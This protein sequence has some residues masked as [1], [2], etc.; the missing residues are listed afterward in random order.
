VNLRRHVL[1]L[2]LSGAIAHASA[3]QPPQPRAAAQS[4]QAAAPI[5]LTGYWVSVITED[6]RFRMVTP[7]KGDF[8]GV[9][10]NAT[11]QKAALS[12]DPAR[13]VASGEQCR[14]YGAGGVMRLPTRLRVSWENDTTLKVETDA[15]QQTR[16]FRFG[17][18]RQEHERTSAN[19]S[20]SSHDWQGYS[21][22]EWETM[23]QGQGQAPPGGGG[24][25]GGQG[26]PALSGALK[27]VTSRMRP[28]YMRR[29]GLPYSDQAILTEYY[30]R[31]NEPSGDSWLILT[32]SLDDSVN[33]TQPFMLTTHFKR[34][35][36]GSKWNPRPCEVVPPLK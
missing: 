33:L 28:G 21:T 26:P 23:P 17:Q 8:V 30:D 25:G 6:W 35:P 31:V 4:P 24:G 29:N 20:P 7:P 12:W 27:V 15:G 19:S 5:D 32:S 14:A 9:P 3:Q 10:L 13:D 34:E 2:C 36:D 16:L 11:G 22:A 1:T 18:S